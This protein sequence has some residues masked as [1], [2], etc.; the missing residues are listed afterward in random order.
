M[1]VPSLPVPQFQAIARETILSFPLLGSFCF[2]MFF[3]FS[4]KIF[5]YGRGKKSKNLDFTCDGMDSAE[6]KEPAG[7]PLPLSLEDRGIPAEK[8]FI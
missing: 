2:F 4:R 5:R 1:L 3:P 6:I 8:L 7:T